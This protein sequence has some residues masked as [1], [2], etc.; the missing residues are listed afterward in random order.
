M[1]VNLSENLNE[2]FSLQTEPTNLILLSKKPDMIPSCSTLLF[3]PPLPS[4]LQ[5]L[6]FLKFST[7]P[8]SHSSH[9]SNFLYF[10]VAQQ[11]PIS[12]SF[13][14][15]SKELLFFCC[16]SPDQHGAKNFPRLWRCFMQKKKG[17][18]G[19]DFEENLRERLEKKAMRR[20][21]KI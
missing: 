3:P 10:L 11:P 13:I 19:T 14:R 12:T 21:R 5:L 2:F 6:I 1:K 8:H 7:L 20:N 4:I 17:K 16:S 15:Q 9:F 18:K